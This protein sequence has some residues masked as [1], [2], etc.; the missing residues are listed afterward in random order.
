MKERGIH[1]RGIQLSSDDGHFTGIGTFRAG[2]PLNTH[3]RTN[4]PW[5]CGKGAI[6]RERR[7]YDRLWFRFR[8]HAAVEPKLAETNR[9]VYG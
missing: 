6:S 3:W 8:R 2:R 9:V 4:D 7:R 5:R 1:G